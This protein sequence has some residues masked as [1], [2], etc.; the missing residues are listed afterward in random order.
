MGFRKKQKLFVNI[1]SLLFFRENS[2]N[3]PEFDWNSNFVYILI[4]FLCF[5]KIL[6]NQSVVKSGLSQIMSNLK[7][8]MTFI[9]IK[10]T[11]FL[12]L[13]HNSLSLT[14]SPHKTRHWGSHPA[15]LMRTPTPV[16]PRRCKPHP[17]H[18][19]VANH[20]EAWPLQTVTDL[21]IKFRGGR[22]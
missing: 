10:D 16:N 5:C 14:P 17:R 15:T 9:P 4:S 1:T 18:C 11:S 8:K 3:I 2:L 19:T 13:C 22:N 7:C 12:T 20:R 6:N 21:G